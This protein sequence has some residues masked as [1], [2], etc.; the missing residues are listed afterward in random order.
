MTFALSKVILYLQCH[1]PYYGF[2]CCFVRKPEPLVVLVPYD[3]H[4]SLL[5][6]LVPL[7][8][9]WLVE[10]EGCGGGGGHFLELMG[11]SK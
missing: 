6:F 2:C 7:P 1:Y 10:N 11:L 4:S 8:L 9:S 5:Q 3:N